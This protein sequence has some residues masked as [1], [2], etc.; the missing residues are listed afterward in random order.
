MDS[1]KYRVITSILWVIPLIFIIFFSYNPIMSIVFVLVVAAIMALALW[2][3][4]NMA[5]KKEWKPL[6][7]LSITA[8]VI[9]VFATYVGIRE[10]T[11]QYTPVF[12]I[13]LTFLAFFLR[14]FGKIENPLVNISISVFGFIYIV[15][16][17]TFIISINFLFDDASLFDG[18][19][20]LL[21]LFV[22]TKFTD[23]G[24]YFLGKAFGQYKLAASI[25]PGKTVEGFF[26][27]IVFSIIASYV[28]YF[29]D[30]VFN[31][32]LG[33]T[34]LQALWLGAL[35][36]VLGQTGDLA[37]SLIKRDVGVKDSNKIPGFGGFLDMVDSI[38][39]TTPLVYAFLRLGILK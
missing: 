29:L 31:G 1:F 9:Y 39:F 11:W 12:I 20:W 6:A 22:V 5:R 7:V 23:V 36:G 3:F 25:S 4:Y 2:E 26:G 24:G 18:R 35:L 16:P 33:L 15:V 19:C 28:L 10:T 30:P 17:L 8:G 13:F 32:A 27:G 14:C 37:E 38:L 21:Y 34:A